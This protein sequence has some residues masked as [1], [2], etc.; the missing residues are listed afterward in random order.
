VT[1]AIRVHYAWDSTRQGHQYEVGTTGSGWTLFGQGSVDVSP[2][3]V[4]A[5]LPFVLS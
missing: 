3:A 1:V 2:W 5:L 4:V